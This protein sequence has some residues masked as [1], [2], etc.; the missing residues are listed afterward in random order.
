MEEDNPFNT[1]NP[2]QNNVENSFLQN[3]HIENN[4]FMQQNTENMNLNQNNLNQQEKFSFHPTYPLP[5]KWGELMRD[6][7]IH[8]NQTTHEFNPQQYSQSHNFFIPTFPPQWGELMSEISYAKPMPPQPPQ[9]L[10][11][12]SPTFQNELHFQQQL[13]QQWEHFQKLQ[14]LNREQ[15]NTNPQFG[16]N[17][18]MEES[19]HKQHSPRPNQN[20]EEKQDPTQFP[21]MMPPQNLPP[22]QIPPQWKIPSVQYPYVP[23][24]TGAP[25]P[26]SPQFYPQSVIPPS[27][28]DEH[29]STT[30]LKP[31]EQ[32]PRKNSNPKKYS[33]NELQNEILSKLFFFF[34]MYLIFN[35][36][37]F[38][39]FIQ[40]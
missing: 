22:N 33:K 5:S 32:R 25:L 13:M 20:P 34:E 24:W 15:L 1:N 11:F 14:Q 10:I 6:I 19:N 23:F 3:N 2:F 9:M 4:N 31:T 35:D 28:G 8:G 7:K 39:I 17:Q 26:F 40:N 37:L 18:S 12:N 29:P 16:T 36:N 38:I 30:R 27:K 21:T